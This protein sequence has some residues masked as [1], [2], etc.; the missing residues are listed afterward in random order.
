MATMASYFAG[1][2]YAD[3]LPDLGDTAQADLSPHTERKIGEAV[4]VEIRLFDPS[5]LDDPEVA[6]YL[7]RLGGR[8]AANADNS[9]QAF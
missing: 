2:S 9:R 7:N 1:T 5:Y 3:G 8:L 6:S 4:M